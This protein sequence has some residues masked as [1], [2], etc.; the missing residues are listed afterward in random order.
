MKNGNKSQ[1]PHL[2]DYNLLTAQDFW[3]A[4]Y[5]ILLII[6]LKEFFET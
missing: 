1:T 6:W 4:H 5:Q 2:A 3:K